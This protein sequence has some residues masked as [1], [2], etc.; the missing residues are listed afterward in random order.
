VSKLHNLFM[1]PMLFIQLMTTVTVKMNSSQHPREES[2]RF[3]D[4]CQVF[5]GSLSCFKM[6]GKQE[7]DMHYPVA[8]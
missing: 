6:F 4:P 5:A 2:L 7:K 1:P 8:C 3:V